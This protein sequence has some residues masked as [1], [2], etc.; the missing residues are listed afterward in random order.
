LFSA[1]L[2]LPLCSPALQEAGPARSS[3]VFLIIPFE[4]VSNA[5]NID[6]ISEAFPAILSARLSSN[7]L[8][9]MSR[10]DGLI[11]L[12]QPGIP[13]G[14]KPSRATIYQV[15]QFDLA[16]N[17]PAAAGQNIEHALAL[18]PANAVAISLKRDIASG[19]AGKPPVPQPL[20]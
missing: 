20:R 11:A 7:W 14:A 17:K 4:N 2:L 3:R 18:D 10:D 12:D 15:A 8:F 5:G 13:A 9:I 19:S 16:D 1:V 6:G